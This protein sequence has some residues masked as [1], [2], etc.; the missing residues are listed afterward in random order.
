MYEGSDTF[1]LMRNITMDWSIY[2]LE[3]KTRSVSFNQLTASIAEKPTHWPPVL[4]V[5]VFVM[6][7]LYH[8][9]NHSGQQGNDQ[10]IRV[11][12]FE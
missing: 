4:F 11:L 1:L 9:Y 8:V 10:V 6:T 7:N 5:V 3:G 12:G 2:F